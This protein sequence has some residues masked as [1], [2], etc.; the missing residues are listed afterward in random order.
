MGRRFSA[1]ALHSPRAAA[2]L[3]VRRC[4]GIAVGLGYEVSVC[5]KTGSLCVCVCVA[6]ITKRYLQGDGAGLW[7]LTK[8]SAVS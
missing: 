4:F 1:P 3:E 2:F 6:L 8:L 5:S 7:G